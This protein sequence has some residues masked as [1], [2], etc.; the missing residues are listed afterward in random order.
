MSLTGSSLMLKLST[1]KFVTRRQFTVV[2]MPD[3]LIE[4]LNNLADEDGMR[5]GSEPYAPDFDFDPKDDTGDPED[6]PPLV[7]QMPPQA[8]AGAS[9]V[10]IG[11]QIRP[12]RAEMLA[13]SESGVPAVAVE[14]E[15][16]AHEENDIG[17][18]ND[19]GMHA[20]DGEAGVQM[21]EAG[22][23]MPEVG[24][25]PIAAEGAPGAEAALPAR[26]GVHRRRTDNR[27]FGT[28]G[29]VLE[30]LGQATRHQQGLRVVPTGEA[31]Q[32]ALTA[33][34]LVELQR[35]HHRAEDVCGGARQG[36]LRHHRSGEAVV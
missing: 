11:P 25:H 16:A 7:L 12:D 24:V 30:S 6:Q 13:G 17:M 2:P 10:P 3:N 27:R 5:G 15:E 35:I 33:L 32:T 9:G 36:S 8:G 19:I 34:T 26:Q 23:Q 21:P 28:S 4:D 31:R 20:D 29:G 18:Q 1:G 14:A 22:V